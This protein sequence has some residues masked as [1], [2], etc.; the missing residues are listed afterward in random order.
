MS[1]TVKEGQQR[2]I[3]AGYDV[4]PDGADG[5]FGAN[6]QTALRKLQADRGLPAS[7]R[8]DYATMA[9][10]FPEDVKPSKGNAMN[11]ILGTIFTGLL[12][13]L[14]RSEAVKGYIRNLLLGLGSTGIVSGVYSGEQWQMIV[15]AAMTVVSVTLSAISANTKQKAMDVVK[16]VDAAPEVTVIPAS[17]TET[18]KPKVIV[19]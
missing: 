1:R 2:L 18:G 8:F 14:L 9:I 19:P 17:Q 16:A 6:T 15:G 12:G 7:G 5:D 3:A 10:L 13:N 4:G 11:G